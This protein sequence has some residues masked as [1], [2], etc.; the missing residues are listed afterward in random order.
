L[1]DLASFHS[2]GSHT[3]GN[4]DELLISIENYTQELQEA[5]QKFKTGQYG[6]E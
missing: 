5:Q 2:A 3:T 4:T 6:T 1:E